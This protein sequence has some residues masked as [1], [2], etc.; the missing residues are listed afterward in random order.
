MMHHSH[1]FGRRFKPLL[2]STIL[3]SQG[4]Q[5]KE[6][7]VVGWIM[8]SNVQ[9]FQ[10]LGRITFIQFFLETIDNVIARL[11]DQFEQLRCG[12]YIASSS[13]SYKGLSG[14]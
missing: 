7:L 5:G 2:K 1:N 8:K 13:S 9:G 10:L 4:Y 12:T 14:K 11:N 6:E 3:E